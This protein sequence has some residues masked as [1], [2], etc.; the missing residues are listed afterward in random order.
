MSIDYN[1]RPKLIESIIAHNCDICG[2]HI[3]GKQ[4]L[5][6]DKYLHLEC[7]NKNPNLPPLWT[8]SDDIKRYEEQKRLIE[9]EYKQREEEYK[10]YRESFCC[11]QFYELHNITIQIDEKG[12]VER[13]NNDDPY[14]EWSERRE[15]LDFKLCPYCGKK[16]L[17]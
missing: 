12:K 10:R 8:E 11:S 17:S 6:E 4:V 13:I 14:Y 1:N 15:D 7:F 2:D 3:F 16:L 5:F 9:E